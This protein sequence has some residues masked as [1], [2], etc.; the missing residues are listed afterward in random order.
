VNT[1]ALAPLPCPFCEEDDDLE[2]S[3][4]VDE[5]MVWCKDCGARGPVCNGVYGFGVDRG[6]VDLWNAAP[7]EATYTLDET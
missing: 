2:V 3:V 1:E 6:A 4:V 5:G 7:R